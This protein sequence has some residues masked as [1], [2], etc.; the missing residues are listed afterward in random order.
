PA[1]DLDAFVAALGVIGPM[2]RTVGDLARMLSVLSGYDPRAPLSSHADP[3]RFA[4]PLDRDVTGTRVG[5]LGDLGGHLAVEPGGLELCRA[6]LGGLEQVGCVVDE[7]L[8]SHP[9][10]HVWQSWLVLRAAQVGSVLK[11]HHRDPAKRVRMK[12]EACWEVER[13][14][15]FTT[16]QVSDA[17]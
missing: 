17:S 3:A 6:G 16:Y 4:A 9:M 15:K 8:L 5:W 10:E 13:G 1:A 11:E 12:P 2:A 14:A 7:V